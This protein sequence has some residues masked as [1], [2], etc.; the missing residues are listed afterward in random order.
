MEGIMKK[1]LVLVL[2]IVS[3][4]VVGAAYAADSL[5]KPGKFDEEDIFAV[6]RLGNKY[7]SIVV[8]DYS[9]EGAEIANIDEGEKKMLDEA[10][11]EIVQALTASTVEYLKKSGKFKTVQSNAKPKGDALILRG[12]FTKFNG[13]VGAAKWFLGFMAP[14]STKT[15]I[16]IEAELVDASTNDVLAKIKDIRSGGEGNTLGSGNM[17]K[18][19][20]IQAKDEGEELAGFI[21]ELY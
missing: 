10:K 6:E 9:T 15:N 3:L 8:Q 21:E 18:A 11:Q 13:G 2:M 5:P 19:F 4:S 20:I 16:S 7:S 12:K 17:T 14:K 1:I